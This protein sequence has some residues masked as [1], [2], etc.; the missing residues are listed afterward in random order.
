LET[1]LSSHSRPEVTVLATQSVIDALADRIASAYRLRRPGWHGSCSSPRVWAAAA[2][3]L[4]QAHRDNPSVPIDPELFVAAQPV[5][6]TYPDPWQELAQAGS[7]R[8]YLRRVRSI[9]RGLRREL[10]SEVR[11]AEDRIGAGQ[12]IARVLCAKSRRL[13]PLGRYIVARRAG[14][15][16]LADRFRDGAVAQ[17]HACPLYRQASIGLVPAAVYPV[18][19]GAPALPATAPAPAKGRPLT[20]VH[21][22]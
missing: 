1:T 9:I 11:L 4:L 18:P 8:C 3:T 15:A 19:D 22:N 14:R 10:A 2:W 13:S 6:T 16:A 20:Q 12:P 21:L 5:D 17:H 7:A